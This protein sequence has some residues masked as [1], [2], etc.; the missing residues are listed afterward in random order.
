[1]D[2]GQED[3]PWRVSIVMSALPPDMLPHSLRHEGAQRVCDLNIFTDGVD[4]KLKN[5]HWYSMKPT[6]W[7]MTFDVR[8][9]V[10]PA[11]LSFQL[12]SRDKRIQ[13][14][15]HEPIAVKWMPAGDFKG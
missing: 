11:D 7:R 10:G 9:V 6:F 1:M 14:S 13:T 5:R 4:K 12:W 15:N 3:Q 2:P 8:V